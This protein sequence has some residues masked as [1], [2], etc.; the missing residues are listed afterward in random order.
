MTTLPSH[1][2]KFTALLKTISLGTTTLTK[3]VSAV[4]TTFMPLTSKVH[5]SPVN[6]SQFDIVTVACIVAALKVVVFVKELIESMVVVRFD[7]RL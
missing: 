2:F 7:M 4:S 3:V 5:S 6:P 1:A